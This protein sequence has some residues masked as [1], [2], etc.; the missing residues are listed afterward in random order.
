M[1]NLLLLFILLAIPLTASAQHTNQYCNAPY[2]FCL[3]VPGS[4]NRIGESKTGDGQFFTATDGS[5]LTVYGT[6]NALDETLEQHF[7]RQLATI[8]TDSLKPAPVEI[9]LILKAET[10]GNSYTLIYQTGNFQN[11]IYRVLQN[12]LWQCLE[13]RF[14]AAK[15]PEYELQMNRM[16]KS[17]R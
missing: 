12:N 8:T 9:P 17:L 11:Y 4:F 6:Y 14:P 10:H 2:N 3:Q 15:A 7:S 1:R 13:M 16:I 5:S